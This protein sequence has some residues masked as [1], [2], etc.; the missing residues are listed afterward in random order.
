MFDTRPKSLVH[1]GDKD[2]PPLT[3]YQDIDEPWTNLILIIPQKL[4][5][6]KDNHLTDGF[7]LMHNTHSVIQKQ[8][9]TLVTRPQGIQLWMW[10]F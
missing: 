2:F 3:A 10:V 7:R 9:I 8:E 5:K 4:L 1:T 6:D